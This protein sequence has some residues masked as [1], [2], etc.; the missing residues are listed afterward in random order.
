[1]IEVFHGSDAAT[2]SAFQ[3][4]RKAHPDGFNLTQKSKRLFIAHWAQDKRENAQGRGCMHQGGSDNECWEDKGSCYT[5]AMKVCSDNLFELLDW[6]AERS[7]SVKNCLHC[8]TRKFPFPS[9]VKT[10]V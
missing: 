10:V 5:T 1:M 3:A 6:A 7:A 4:W 2:H 8:D 9:A